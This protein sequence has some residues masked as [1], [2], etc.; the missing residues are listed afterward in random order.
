LITLDKQG[1]PLPGVNVHTVVVP[2]VYRVSEF[3]APADNYTHLFFIFETYKVEGDRF[4]RLVAVRLT[5]STAIAEACE[6]TKSTS[7][8]FVILTAETFIE[9]LDLLNRAKGIAF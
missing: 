9:A 6:R 1:N 2:N 4:N 3:P 8:K 7:S 5:E